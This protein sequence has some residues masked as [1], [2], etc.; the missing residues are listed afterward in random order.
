MPGFHE[1]V[2]SLSHLLGAFVFMGLAWMVIRNSGRDWLCMSSLV[3]AAC[4]TVQLLLISGL[5]HMMPPGPLRDTLHLVDVSA[6]FLMIAGSMTPV[7]AILFKGAGRWV[8]LAT[9]W[10]AAFAGIAYR[11]ANADTVSTRAGTAIFLVFGWGAV[12]TACVLWQR[13]GWAFVRAGVLSGLT[14]TLGAG[15]LVSN[16]PLLVKGMVGP[17]E[18]WHVA[19]LCALGLYWRFVSQFASGEIPAVIMPPQIVRMR[20]PADQPATDSSNLRRAA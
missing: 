6:I 9:A 17:H 14:Y 5:Y 19:V 13:H 15:I 8:P 20:R 12:L 2:S 10:L 11:C 1:P 7:H 3:I 16:Q 4:C 18:L